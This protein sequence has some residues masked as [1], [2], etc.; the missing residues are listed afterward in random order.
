[1]QDKDKVLQELK[2]KKRCDPQGYINELFKNEAAGHDL[3]KS[4]LY[5]MNK[6]K[7]LLENPDMMKDVNVVMIPKPKKKNILKIN[8]GFFYLVFMEAYY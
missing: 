5:M 7:Y 2:K 1:M 3:K 8:V 4:L 6:A